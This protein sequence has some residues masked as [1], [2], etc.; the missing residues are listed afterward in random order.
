MAQYQTECLKLLQDAINLLDASQKWENRAQIKAQKLGIQGEKRREGHDERKE[1]CLA[2]YLQRTAM[3]IF[4]AELYPEVGNV[5]APAFSRPQDYFTAYHA[6]L[7][8]TYEALHMIA[9][10]LVVKGYK[11]IAGPMYDYACYMFDEIID[12]RRQLKEYALAGWEYHHI[13]RYQVS[14]ENRHDDYEKKERK[15]GYEY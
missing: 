10:E 2:Q 1:L 14:Y 3:D 9:N 11:P 4:D 5:S 13:S 15:Q 8:E 7:W 6:K 12:T